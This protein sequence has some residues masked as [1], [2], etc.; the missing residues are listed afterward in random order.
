M[1]GLEWTSWSNHNGDILIIGAAQPG[2][3]FLIAFTHDGRVMGFKD[4]VYT[5][6]LSV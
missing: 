5:E 2:D 3:V 4:G 6:W 1:F